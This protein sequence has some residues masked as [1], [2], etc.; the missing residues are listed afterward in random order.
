[1]GGLDGDLAVVLGAACWA[2][3][4]CVVGDSRATGT[5]RSVRRPDGG[6]EAGPF[7]CVRRRAEVVG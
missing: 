3:A 6:E 1:V 7:L 5:H 4:C 2:A